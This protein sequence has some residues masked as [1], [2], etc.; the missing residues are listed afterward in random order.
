M[1]KNN[2][3]IIIVT[4]NSMQWIQKC[5]DSCEGYLIVV[6]DNNS[7]DGTVAFIYE[8][9]PKVHLMSQKEN[10]GFGQA[11]NIGIDY[12]LEQGADYVFLLNQDAYLEDGCIKKLIEIHS[13]NKDYGILSPV[14]LDGKGVRLDKNFSNYLAYRFNPDFYSDF[15]LKKPLKEIYEIPFVNAAGWLLS[16]DILETVGGFDPIFFHYGEDDNYCQRAKYHGFKIGVVP[17]VFLQHDRADRALPNIEKGSV[18]FFK[19]MQRSLKMKYGNINIENIDELKE[20]IN[21]RKKNKIKVSLKMKFSQVRFLNKEIM[22]L[23]QMLPKIQKSRELNKKQGPN[24]LKKNSK[25]L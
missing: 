11:N 10:L 8:N 5:L 7:T 2:T 6:V 23:I 25:Y 3:F 21:K 12:A 22:L 13:L 9:F 18:E 16:K 14:H 1:I 19:Q 20:I 24:Y 4:Y 15:V 17:T